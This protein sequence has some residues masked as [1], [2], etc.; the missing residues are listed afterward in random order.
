MSDPFRAIA[1]PT[2]R[3]ILDVLAE[4]ERSVSE[5]CACF[6]VSQP[7]ISQHLAVL[8]DAGLVVVRAE[9]RQRIYALHADPLRE[10]HD[11][12]SH[13]ERFWSTKLDALGAVLAREARKPKITKKKDDR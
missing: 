12:S 8:R 6:D 1:D 13:Y 7:A 3:A 4:G 10:V 9:G 5:L 2:R 11:W